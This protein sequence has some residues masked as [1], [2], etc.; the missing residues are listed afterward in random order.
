MQRSPVLRNSSKVIQKH[1]RVIGGRKSVPCRTEITIT[2]LEIAVV[3][4]CASIATLF[5]SKYATSATLAFIPLAAPRNTHITISAS[6][7]EAVAVFAFC[8]CRS[9]VGKSALSP[10][11]DSP[12]ASIRNKLGSLGAGP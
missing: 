5:D 6:P 2:I 8:I 3:M 7:V 10:S 1:R 11:R 9:R 12:Q 4:L